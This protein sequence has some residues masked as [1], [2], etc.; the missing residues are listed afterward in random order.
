MS[1]NR[2]VESIYLEK[3]IIDILL[4]ILSKNSAYSNY[5]QTMAESIVNKKEVSD[6]E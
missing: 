4:T 3:S 6:D 2:E 5:V 1:H